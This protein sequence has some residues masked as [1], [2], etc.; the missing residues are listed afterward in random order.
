MWKLV[1]KTYYVNKNGKKRIMV[2]TL[3][4]FL[5]HI[6]RIINVYL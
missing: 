2:A 5:L 1:I 6:D 4:G 3:W